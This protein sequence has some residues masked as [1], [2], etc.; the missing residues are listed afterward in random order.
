MLSLRIQRLMDKSAIALSTAC[1]IHCLLLP[2]IL[3]ALPAL[4]ST[5]V[6]NESFHRFLIWFVFPISVLALVQGCRRHKNRIV[7]AS[8]VLG[9][10]LLVATAFFGHEVLSEDGERFAT[11]LGATVLAFGHFH[12]Y[13]LCR[14]NKCCQ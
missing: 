7:L 14:K 11:V 13:R 8:G 2:L 10:A 3:V 4:G 12:N 9:L 6:G 5:F 1:A